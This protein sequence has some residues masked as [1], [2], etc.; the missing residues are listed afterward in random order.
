MTFKLPKLPY[1]YSAL[2]PY[3]DR[4]TMTIHHKKHHQAYVD[5]LNK[6]LVGVKQ[7]FTSP[8]DI[9]KNIKKIP[10]SVRQAVINNGGGH[11]N[12][13]FFWKIML[14]PRAEGPRGRRPNRPTGELLDMINAKFRSVDKFKEEFNNKAMRV[15]GSGWAF[16]VMTPKGQ[17]GLKRHSFQNSPHL[18]GNI[19][20]L[21]IDV[22][23]HAYY[24]KYQ[25]RRADYIKAWWNVVNWEQVAENFRLATKTS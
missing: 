9:L 5:N 16:L 20:L 13:T 4:Q 1:S 2:E 21:G 10:I 17:I 8:E 23:E 15:F 24:L 6:A 3:I 11:V 25:N 7:R 22:W 19:P 18:T 14:P 12:H